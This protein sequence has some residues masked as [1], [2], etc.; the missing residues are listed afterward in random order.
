MKKLGIQDMTQK[1]EDQTYIINQT[2]ESQSDEISLLAI[3]QLLDEKNLKTISRLN[4]E[5]ISI[6]T[7]LYLFSDTFKT[8][9]TKAL[10]DNILKLQ[11]SIRG[12]GRRELVQLVQRR[13]GMFDANQ[14]IKSSKDIFR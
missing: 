14:P 1:N 12:L 9:F 5:Q 6:L 10:A 11:I 3:N 4:P 7:K 13:D 2:E 8:P